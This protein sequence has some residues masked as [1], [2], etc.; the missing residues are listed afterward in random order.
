[1]MYTISMAASLVIQ[2]VLGFIPPSQDSWGLSAEHS[3]PY[4]PFDRC[5]IQAGLGPYLSSNATLVLPSNI[6]FQSL[7]VRASSPRIQPNF[8]AIV[9]VATEEDVQY[10]VR[11]TLCS[12]IEQY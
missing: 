9:E 7:E 12:R 3:T 2:S 8:T 10:T 5:D 11:H 6:T 4:G 1:M